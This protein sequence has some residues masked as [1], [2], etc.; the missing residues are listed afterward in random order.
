MT[1]SE[2]VQTHGRE[3]LAAAIGVGS[4]YL[5]QMAYGFRRV[6]AH[7]CLAIEAATK[8]AVTRYELRPDVFGPAPESSDAA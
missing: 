1:L 2:Y 8:G 4:A 5:Y 7:R 3:E 6:P